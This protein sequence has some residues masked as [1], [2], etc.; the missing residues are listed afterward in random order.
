MGYGTVRLESSPHRANPHTNGK[1][2]LRIRDVHPGSEFFPSRIQGQKDSKS[3]SKNLCILTQKL[4]QSSRK[5]DPGCS[6][7]IRIL[8]FY[9]SRIPGSKRPPDPGSGSATLREGRF[10]E[11][12]PN[13]HRG[14]SGMRKKKDRVGRPISET[15]RVR[16]LQC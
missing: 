5:C 9:P 16:C 15:A 14:L 10:A 6:S 4:F 1:A 3:A 11:I 7:R 2:V 13:S 12:S 8:I